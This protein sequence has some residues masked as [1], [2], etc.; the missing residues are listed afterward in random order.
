MIKGSYFHY[1][2]DEDGRDT[3]SGEWYSTDYKLR[4]PSVALCLD[5]R[6]KMDETILT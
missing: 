2:K 1:D 4:V 3:T 6:R 5:W